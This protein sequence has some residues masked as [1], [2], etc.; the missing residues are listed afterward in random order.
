MMRKPLLIARVGLFSALVYVLS[1]GTLYL[2]NVNFVFFIV[3][4]AGFLWGAVPG[5]L[6]GLIGMGLWT[7]FNPYGPALPPIM[8][9]QV[10]GAAGSGVVGALFRASRWQWRNPWV[11]A[12]SLILSAFL[13]TIVF[14]LPVNAVD[15][16][17]FQPFWPRFVGGTLWVAFSLAFNVI[18]FPVFFMA[19]KLIR[20]FSTGESP[21][22]R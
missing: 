8:I 12:L 11:L 21:F 18:I 14:H 7:A 15:A 9:A 4:F 22:Q 19:F 20:H 5:I 3:F 1:W 13:C 6:V 10:V 2:P 17:L 16:W